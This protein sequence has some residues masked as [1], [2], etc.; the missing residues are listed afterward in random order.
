[1]PVFAYTACDLQQRTIEGE[2]SAPSR[3]SASRLLTARGMQ[4]VRI[5]EAK[6]GGRQGNG[7]TTAQPTRVNGG[8]APDHYSARERLPFLKALTALVSS[9]YPVGEALRLM[10][11]RLK[12]DKLRSLS[13]ALWERLSAG[14]TF[15]RALED[16]PR[17][18]DAQS[19]NLIRAGE[20]TGNVKEVLRRLI[21]HYTALQQLHRRVI[22]ALCYPVFICVVATGVL[23]FFAI[24]L[25]PRLQGLLHSLGGTLP[26]A[27]RIL[28]SASH[29]LLVYGPVAAVVFTLGVIGLWQWSKTVRGREALDAL[30]LRLPLIGPLTVDICVQNFCQT[31]TVLLENG[32]TTV[33]A[34]RIAER[35]VS[36]RVLSRGFRQAADAIVEGQSVTRALAQVPRLPDAVLDRFSLGENTG[37][38]APHLRDLS[39]EMEEE[40]TH[41]LKAL[42]DV[43]STVVLL[44]AFSFVG[45]VAYA[46]V[47][48]VF[49]VSASF[50]F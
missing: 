17:T 11:R 41:R 19:I 25:M 5:R 18:F 30:I 10:P 13:L 26:L 2:L 12:D 37:N 46:T 7:Q 49:Q 35:T 22:A 20:A 4:P 39:T 47:S 28:L 3:Q 31:L 6:S 29:G 40:L 32:I 44:L 45:F 15:S 21:Q 36:N 43:M 16:F 50:K 8:H 9:G 48:A 1:M 33:E 42:T 27:T 24:F 34:L 38:L 23:L 14:A